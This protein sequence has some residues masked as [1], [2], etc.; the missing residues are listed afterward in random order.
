MET[1]TA[2]LSRQGTALF[3]YMSIKHQNDRRIGDLT[4][5]DFMEMIMFLQKVEKQNESN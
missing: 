2:T 4:L 1:D 5:G 3:N